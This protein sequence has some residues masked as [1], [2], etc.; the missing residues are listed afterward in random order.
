MEI[1]LPPGSENGFLRIVPSYSDGKAKVIC[2]AK[3]T[4]IT[5]PVEYEDTEKLAKYIIDRMG[6]WR[7]CRI[8]LEILKELVEEKQN[9]ELFE[10]INSML[11]GKDERL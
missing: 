5:F 10:E 9:S 2:R 8:M 4:V 3:D 11:E 1:E 7:V 6:W